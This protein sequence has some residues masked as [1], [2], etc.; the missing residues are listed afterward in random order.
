MLKN[1]PLY[2]CNVVLLIYFISLILVR[3][4]IIKL[5]SPFSLAVYLLTWAI[6]VIGIPLVF[7]IGNHIKKTTTVKKNNTL[8]YII[9]LSHVAVIPFLLYFIPFRSKK[10]TKKIASK[11]LVIMIIIVALYY[12]NVRL[13]GYTIKEVYK[14]DDKKF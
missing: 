2:Y 12:A 5:D 14:L 3:A 13:R 9:L 6:P 10:I 11:T 8:F 1:F 7:Y 4:D